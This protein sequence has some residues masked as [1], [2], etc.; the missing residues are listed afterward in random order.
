MSVVVL[1]VEMRVLGVEMLDH[2][3]EMLD[4]GVEMLD[5]GVEAKWQ[6]LSWSSG[7]LECRQHMW[8]CHNNLVSYD[9]LRRCPISFTSR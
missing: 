5:R 9:R 7:L 1:G 8:L 6:N 4:R 2:G 3:V